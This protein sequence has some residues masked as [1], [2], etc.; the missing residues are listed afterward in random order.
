MLPAA[1]HKRLQLIQGDICAP[2][3]RRHSI[4]L[5]LAAHNTF[6]HLTPREALTALKAMRDCLAPNGRLILD[7]ANPFDLWQMPGDSAIEPEQAV[8]DPET[9]ETILVSSSSKLDEEAQVL[10]VTWYFDASRTGALQIRRA[11][12]TTDYHFLFPHE[13]E[14]MVYDAGLTL[15]ELVGDYDHSPYAESSPRMIVIAEKQ[16]R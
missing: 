1:A 7:L 5:A 10:R 9:G 6:M 3:L 11:E 12:A 13:M 15:T 4:D 2:P 8:Q 14:R 16:G